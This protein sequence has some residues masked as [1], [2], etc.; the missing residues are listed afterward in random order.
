MRSRNSVVKTTGID[1]IVTSHMTSTFNMADVNVHERDALVATPTL[2]SNNGDQKVC[3]TRIYH[4]YMLRT[5]T[6]RPS[7]SLFGIT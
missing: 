6:I 7:G 5:E 3:K 4:G 1:V 2:K